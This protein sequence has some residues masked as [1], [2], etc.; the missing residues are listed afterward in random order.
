MNPVFADAHRAGTVRF[1]MPPDTLVN[2]TWP[3]FR[4]DIRVWHMQAAVLPAMPSCPRPFALSGRP[5]LV[6][7]PCDTASALVPE[8]P[9][10]QTRTRHAPWSGAPRLRFR[11]TVSCFQSAL[12]DYATAL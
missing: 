10:V 3:A 2:Q 5:L 9:F 4:F 6:T 11:L 7:C 12:M 8:P 1:Q